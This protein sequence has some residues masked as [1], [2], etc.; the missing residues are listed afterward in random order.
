MHWVYHQVQYFLLH[1]GYWA[2]LVGVMGED[3]G[4]PFPGETVLMFASFVSHKNGGLALAWIIVVG[5]TAAIIG[6]NLGFLLGRLLGTRLMRWLKRLAHMDEEDVGAARY[7]VKRHGKATIFWARF[8]F[9]LRTFAGPIAGVLGMEWRD[10]VVYNAL[11]AAAWVTTV[12]LIGY[13]FAS[14]FQTLLG[15]FEKVSWA[16]GLALLSVGYLL[17]RRQKKRYKARLAKQRAQG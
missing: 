5:I 12:S 16:L 1:W 15:F 13:A 11:G 2:V 7:H 17:W 4:L 8:I 14:E 3:A 9:G 10:F 6:D